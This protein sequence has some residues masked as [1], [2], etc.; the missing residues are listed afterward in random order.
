MGG[1]ALTALI[2]VPLLGGA[3]VLLQSEDEAIWRSVD[4]VQDW[5]RDGIDRTMGKYN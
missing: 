4:A 3:V 1:F 5:A 2:F